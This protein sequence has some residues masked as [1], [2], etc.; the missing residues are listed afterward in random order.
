MEHGPE[1][2]FGNKMPERYGPGRFLEKKAFKR[3][4]L[5]E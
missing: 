1:K 2:N 3:G 5:P 4:L